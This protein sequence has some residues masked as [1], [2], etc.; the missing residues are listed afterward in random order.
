[1]SLAGKRSTLK[2]VDSF[3]EPGS[4]MAED[5]LRRRLARDEA[6]PADL[7]SVS[8]GQLREAVRGSGRGVEG[9]DLF[10]ALA[11][12]PDVGK[13]AAAA[14]EI[15]QE[16]GDVIAMA[17]IAAWLGHGGRLHREAAGLLGRAFLERA[18]DRASDYGARAQALKAAMI[19]AQ[20]DRAL[21]RRLQAEMIELDPADDGDFLR[22]AA[23]VTGALLAREPDPDLHAVLGKLLDVEEAEDE[24]AMELGLDAL[25]AGLDATTQD[26]ALRSFREAR[27]W[28]GRSEAASEERPDARLYRRCLDM[29]VAFQTG[30]TQSDLRVGIDGIKE[31]A[32]AYT[33]HLSPS[34]RPEEIS[35]WLGARGRE[36][37]HWS[38]LAL[39][40]GALDTSL[41][42]RAWLNAATVIQDELVSVYSASRSIM[43]RGGDGGLEAVLRPR[44]VGAL[45]RELHSLDTLDQW[46]EENS[47]S[48]LLPDVSGLRARVAEAR[49]GVVAHRPTE[50]APG[51]SPAAAILESIP[52]AGRA[53]AMARVAGAMMTLVGES[54]SAV[55]SDLYD[56]IIRDLGRNEHFRRYPEA[57]TLFEI[58]LWLTLQF[59]AQRSNV[60][61]STYRRAKYLFERDPAKLPLEETLQEDYL[62]FLWGSPS[63]GILGAE[64]SDIAGGRVDVLFKHMRT[65]FVAELKKTDRKLTNDQIVAKY[66]L[67]KVAY[68]VTNVSFGILMMLD[69]YDLGGGQPDV[70]ERISV[71]HVTP[72]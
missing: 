56:D 8:P 21:L 10:V 64:A 38:M 25:R 7:S 9:A 63:A 11:S 28:F 18:G 55:V 22:H 19:L 5:V 16:A 44:I 27:D 29:L 24:V 12:H 53:S 61:S 30:R 40:L 57:R 50:A 62:D 66:G 15:V 1:M 39:R 14:V 52:E 2:V 6:E 17:G 67:Q 49:E 69:L 58:A 26:D 42:K 51:S 13:A 3:S 34:D 54:T 45:Q 4:T 48:G 65:T 20:S 68:D 71:H 32:F 47:G 31:A 35:S 70:A 33:A 36:R 41:G 46:I 60:G 72:P 37:V 43:V 23:N 59:V